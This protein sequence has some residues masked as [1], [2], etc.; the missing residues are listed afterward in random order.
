MQSF[1][2]TE[3]EFNDTAEELLLT[4]TLAGGKFLGLVGLGERIG[5]GSHGSILLRKYASPLPSTPAFIYVWS[6][7]TYI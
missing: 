3:S 5:S 7:L 6:R 1:C 4:F 2:V